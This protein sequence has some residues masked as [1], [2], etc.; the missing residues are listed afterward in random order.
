MSS[1]SSSSRAPAAMARWS[2]RSAPVAS[3]VVW[4]MRRC[5]PLL[6]DVAQRGGGTGRPLHDGL[7]L[8]LGLAEP[9]LAVIAE[10]GPPLV[11][12]DGLGQRAAPLLQLRHDGL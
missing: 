8:R 12:G 4:L 1:A 5:A 3:I 7:H 10:R 2:A 6:L 9:R 11:V